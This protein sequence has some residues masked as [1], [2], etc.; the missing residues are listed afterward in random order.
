MENEL[1]EAFREAREA[2]KES[3]ESSREEAL[4]KL[5]ASRFDYVRL[6]EYHYRIEGIVDWWPSTGRWMVQG[7]AAGISRIKGHGIKR[8]LVYLEQVVPND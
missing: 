2:R 5:M 8:L 4:A 7:R 1:R 3:R 6:S